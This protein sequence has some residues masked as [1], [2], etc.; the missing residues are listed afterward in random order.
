MPAVF[1]VIRAVLQKKEVFDMAK[2]TNVPGH[3]IFRVSV[4]EKNRLL[5]LAAQ[6][7]KT[8]SAFCRDAAIAAGKNVGPMDGGQARH[9][10]LVALQRE[11][12]KN[13]Y[14]IVRMV[15]FAASAEQ[16]HSEED[17]V[18][19]YESTVKKAEKIYG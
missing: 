19:F 5:L 1:R 18:N 3:V 4:N 12:Q 10:E 17:V 7:G 8:L 15:L 14:V 2:L 11:T 9:D 6:N 16:R 13:L